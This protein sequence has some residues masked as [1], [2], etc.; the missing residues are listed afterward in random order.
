MDLCTKHGEIDVN[1]TDVY[2]EFRKKGNK[3]Q[4]TSLSF[5]ENTPWRSSA[6]TPTV[7]NHGYGFKS[8]QLQ[9]FSVFWLV[10]VSKQASIEETAD[11][12]ASTHTIN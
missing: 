9:A 7:L 6:M 1:V 10:F 8:K 2:F 4:S 3:Y 11:R 5:V 12:I